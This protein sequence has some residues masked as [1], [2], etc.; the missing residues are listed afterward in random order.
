MN[1]VSESTPVVNPA[2]ADQATEALPD[3]T[4]D[5]AAGVEKL[6]P[7]G[8]AVASIVAIFVAHYEDESKRTMAIGRKAFN[9]M[10]KV[11]KLFESGGVA[12]WA[13]CDWEDQCHRI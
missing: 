10:V 11:R 3:S 5:V 1:T 7:I 8:Q 13:K 2:M 4:I 9:H 6:S 12:V